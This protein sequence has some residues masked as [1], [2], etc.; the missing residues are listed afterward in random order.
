MR[1]AKKFLVMGD[2]H[3]TNI[4]L[5]E[6]IK[7]E[8]IDGI[9][10]LGDFDTPEVLLKLKKVESKAKPWDLIYNPVSDDKKLIV[11]YVPGD[12]DYSIYKNEKDI[13][14]SKL[15][16]S[17]L[18]GRKA[19]L[20]KTGKK[21]RI[22]IGELSRKGSASLFDL[23]LKLR[24]LRNE[25]IKCEESLNNLKLQKRINDKA[26]VDLVQ[27]Y[28]ELN[29]EFSTTYLS[30]LIL[31]Y[32]LAHSFLRAHFEKNEVAFSK[33][34][35]IINNSF[36]MIGDKEAYYSKLYFK[37]VPAYLIHGAFAGMQKPENLKTPP[38]KYNPTLSA[39]LAIGDYKNKDIVDPKIRYLSL[40][41]V[42][43]NFKVMKEDNIPLMFKGHDHFQG[44]FSIP[45][46]YFEKKGEAFELLKREISANEPI[47]SN[48]LD[49]VTSDIKCQINV[50]VKSVQFEPN[51]IYI[52]EPGAMYKGEYAVF[53]TNEMKV[54]F[55][56]SYEFALEH[57]KNTTY[58]KLV[59][60]K[61]NLQQS[62]NKAWEGIKLFN[63]KVLR[64]LKFR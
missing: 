17:V 21:I 32:E 3:G 61:Y 28:N 49:Y 42:L 4:R 36:T 56:N 7:Y 34:E 64:L 5:K 15:G 35:N 33:L 10:S 47:S 30:Y 53:D 16:D 50:G 43:E 26:F 46:D 23:E 37:G 54:Y 55:R 58:Q 39:T 29:S 9:I 63:D 62:I 11:H 8:E 1:G 22:K 25:K 24:D 27:K 44:Y 40:I 38:S 57:K 41:Y 12:T 20:D 6:I 59:N 19:H 13:Y 48:E 45:S 14:N 2:Y 51:R 52:I 31:R 18:S 60:T